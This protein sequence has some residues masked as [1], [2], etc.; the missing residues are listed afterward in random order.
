MP[1]DLFHIKGISRTAV[2]LLRIP[3]TMERRWF[4]GDDK[5]TYVSVGASLNYASLEEESERH[6]ATDVNN[7]P[8]EYFYIRLQ[9]NNNKKPWLNY[10]IGGGHAWMLKN[11]DFISAGIIANLSLTRFINGTFTMDIPGQPKVEGNYSFK[12]SYASLTVCYVYTGTKKRLR[13]LTS[14]D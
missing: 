10:H 1:N 14:R 11:K 13:R 3:V 12:G 4:S 7:Q 6:L 9:T 5:Y 2:F 8:T